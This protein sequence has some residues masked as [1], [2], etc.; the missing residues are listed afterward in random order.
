MGADL[1]NQRDLM[2]QVYDSGRY[3]DMFMRPAATAN[4]LPPGRRRAGA[5]RRLLGR[6]NRIKSQRRSRLS[7]GRAGSGA[8]KPTAQGG[9]KGGAVRY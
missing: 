8:T 4:H 5:A 9:N 3:E 7:S 1:G 2:K 6:L